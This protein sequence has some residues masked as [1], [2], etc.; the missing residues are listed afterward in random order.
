MGYGDTIEEMLEIKVYEMGGDEEIFTFEAWRCAFDINEPIYT[1]P[2]HEFYV[3]Y[4]FDEAVTDEYLMWKKVIKFRLGGR[5]HTLTILEFARRLGLYTSNEIQD[6]GFETYFLISL[7]NDDHFNV[8]QYWSEISSENELILSRSSVRS[9]RKPVLRVLQKMIT[10]GLCERTTG[11][12][13]V[14]RNE[15][16]LMSLYEEKHQNGLMWRL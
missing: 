15:L 11:S 7:R 16:W 1:E 9:I 10:Y 8:N 6:E 14:Q 3:T 5:S 4:E 12:D 13:K 2:C